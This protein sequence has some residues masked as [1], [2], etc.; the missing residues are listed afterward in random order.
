MNQWRHSHKKKK[1][2]RQIFV[3]SSK[4]TSR[5]ENIR[6]FKKKLSHI[7]LFMTVIGICYNFYFDLRHF[8]LLLVSVC[9][10]NKIKSNENSWPYTITSRWCIY[11]LARGRVVLV[12]FG[13]VLILFN[14]C[15]FLVSSQLS[16]YQVNVN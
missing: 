8:F 9:I 7:H 13:L 14:C 1:K 12:S 10:L 11:G 4:W 15:F 3:I 6:K 16:T 5:I 2:L